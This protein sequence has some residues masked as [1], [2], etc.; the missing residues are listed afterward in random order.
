MI[1]DLIYALLFFAIIALG[2][3]L[4]TLVAEAGSWTTFISGI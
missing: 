3:T 2:H 4:V 1:E